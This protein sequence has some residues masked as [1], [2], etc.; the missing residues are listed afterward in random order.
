MFLL[1]E[2]S[3]GLR[4]QG[5]QRRVAF[6]NPVLPPSLNQVWIRGLRVADATIDLLASRHREGDVSVN[7]IRREGDVEVMILK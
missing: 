2:S 1:L 7:V 4:V 3:L 6:S 5:A